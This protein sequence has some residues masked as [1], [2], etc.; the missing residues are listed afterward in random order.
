MQKTGHPVAWLVTTCGPRVINSLM[1]KKFRFQVPRDRSPRLRG[2]D[3]NS[4]HCLERHCAVDFRSFTHQVAVVG[5]HCSRP[6]CPRHFAQALRLSPL[7]GL[8]TFGKCL[9]SPKFSSDGG[10]RF[11]AFD[12]RPVSCHMQPS[13]VSLQRRRD[14]LRTNNDHSDGLEAESSVQPASKSRAKGYRENFKPCRIRD[15]NHT[16]PEYVWGDEGPVN[17]RRETS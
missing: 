13:V 2:R 14:M 11:R 5:P 10:N 12:S 4:K 1:L 16:N 6:A 8:E 3:W 7:I 17:E 9:I 15:H